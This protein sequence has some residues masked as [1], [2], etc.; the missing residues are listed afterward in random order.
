VQLSDIACTPQNIQQP[1]NLLEKGQLWLEEI[2]ARIGAKLNAIFG[3]LEELTRL[4]G[5]DRLHRMKQFNKSLIQW[6][7]SAQDI[8]I[9]QGSGL[10]SCDHNLG[11][12][13]L[14]PRQTSQELTVASQ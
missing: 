1:K 9:F 6:S 12:Q 3:S 14:Q 7:S 13:L 5:D 8:G 10:L 11:R 4:L 2:T